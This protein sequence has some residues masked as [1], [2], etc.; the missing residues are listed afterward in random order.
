MQASLAAEHGAAK[1]YLISRRFLDW[2]TPERLVG[3][4]SPTASLITGGSAVAE[5]ADARRQIQLEYEDLAAWL[6]LKGVKD[7]GPDPSGILSS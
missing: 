3:R 6:R 5:L 1:V 2:A 7:L 4:L